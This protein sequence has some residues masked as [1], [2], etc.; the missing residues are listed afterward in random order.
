MTIN[1][2]DTALL[3][4]KEVMEIQTVGQL[5]KLFPKELSDQDKVGVIQINRRHTYHLIKKQNMKVTGEF[6]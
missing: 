5:N 3:N 2:N 1:F 4:F 6:Y